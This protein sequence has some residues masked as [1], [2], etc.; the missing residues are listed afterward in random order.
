MNSIHKSTA[1]KSD[2]NEERGTINRIKD[3]VKT[4]PRSVSLEVLI[5]YCNIIIIMAFFLCSLPRQV[6]VF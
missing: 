1:K 2:S 3:D 4:A 6:L 5:T